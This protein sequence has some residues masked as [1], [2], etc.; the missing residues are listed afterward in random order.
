MSEEKK[1]KISFT[2]SPFETSDQTRTSLPIKDHVQPPVNKLSNRIIQNVNQ[3]SGSNDNSQSLEDKLRYPENTISYPSESPKITKAR[4]DILN[5]EELDQEESIVNEENSTNYKNNF[6]AFKIYRY[7][8][9]KTK[10][11]Y[12]SVGKEI[13]I[14]RPGSGLLSFF[15]SYIGASLGEILSS[16]FSRYKVLRQLQNVQSFPE[17]NLS[18]KM[19]PSLKSIISE[20]GQQAL[21][22]GVSPN[23][24]KH[25]IQ[26]FFNIMFIEQYKGVVDKDDSVFY[27]FKL[28][29]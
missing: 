9:N 28:V 27:I 13:P 17:L 10:N 19:I 26:L 14:L 16:P 23:I 4:L 21:F 8:E 24:Y 20:Q 7:V 22:R 11:Y 25:A 2:Q 29:P 6:A 15:A 5:N 12:Y 1:P 18:A 3:E